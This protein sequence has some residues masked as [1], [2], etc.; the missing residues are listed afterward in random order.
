[1][2]MY[3][4]IMTPKWRLLY[5]NKKGTAPFMIFY[6]PLRVYKDIKG[7]VPFFIKGAVPNVTRLGGYVNK[8]RL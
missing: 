8:M 4:I 1:M 5:K 7:A 2:N 3:L 6:Y